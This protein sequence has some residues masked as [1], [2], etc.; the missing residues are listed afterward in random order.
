MRTLF[1]KAAALALA[2][3]FTASAQSLP[4]LCR[5]LGTV[6]VGQW[7]EYRLTAQDM[8]PQP[9]QMRFAIVGSEAVNGKDHQWFEMKIDMAQGSMVM[10]LLVP[11]WPYTDGDVAGI[12]V[13]APGQPAMR[14]PPQMMAMM[15]QQRR[16]ASPEDMLREC[17]SA[18]VVG[19]EQL[20]V[21]AGTFSTVRIQPADGENA[22]VWVAAG[23]PFAMV[24]MKSPEAELVLLRHGTDA[25]SS[26]TETPMQMP[27]GR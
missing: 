18:R 15:A 3:P 12:V 23:V 4:D 5:S 19:R 20:T 24:Q 10:Q 25:R 1:A 16:G 7:A 17:A 6:R 14:L 13:K 8:G 26:I 27:G 22:E 9:A 21:P 11:N 2:V